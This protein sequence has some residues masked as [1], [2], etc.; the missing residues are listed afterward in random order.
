MYGFKG[1][2]GVSFSLNRLLGISGI[3][4]SIARKTGIPTT[5]GG[6]E[7]KI[8]RKIIDTIFGK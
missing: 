5:R 7:R 8:G 4:N 3:K 1:K 2:Y 6:I